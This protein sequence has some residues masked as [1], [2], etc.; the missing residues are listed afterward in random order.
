LSRRMWS[1]PRSETSALGALQGAMEEAMTADLALERAI[2]A[3]LGLELPVGAELDK[4]SAGTAPDLSASS[5]SPPG[6][7]IFTDLNLRALDPSSE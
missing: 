2:R 7:V 5:G 6:G 3:D 4:D 1:R